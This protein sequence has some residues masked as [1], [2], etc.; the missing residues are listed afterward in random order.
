MMERERDVTVQ[1]HCSAGT[2]LRTIVRGHLDTL[3]A[4]YSKVQTLE[5][6]ISTIPLLQLSLASSNS[7]LDSFYRIWIKMYREKDRKYMQ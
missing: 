6:Y 1:K 5:N 7:N 3:P 2:A 4:G